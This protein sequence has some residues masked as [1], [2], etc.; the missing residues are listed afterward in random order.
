MLAFGPRLSGENGFLPR[1]GIVWV[2]GRGVRVDERHPW[3]IEAE[4]GVPEGD[5]G[6]RPPNVAALAGIDGNE[7]GTG[8]W[9]PLGRAAGA[10]R[11]GLNWCRI[12]AGAEGAPPH[13]HSAEE[14][15]FVVLEGEG[16]LELWAPPDPAEPRQQAPRETHRLRPGHVVS[17]PPGT[18]VPHT[19]R[20]APDAPV[21]YL[22]YGTRDPS[23]VCW[24]PRSN[25][26]FLRGVGMIARLEPLE[27][28]DGEPG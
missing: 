10:V 4:L 13:C 27:Y 19:I 12:A 18:R 3:A 1:S 15:L 17:R 28:S 25:K 7:D 11:T 24:Y 6:E 2:A 26:V 5:P 22:A 14:E 9:K 8:A 16:I 21:T 23:D 20:A